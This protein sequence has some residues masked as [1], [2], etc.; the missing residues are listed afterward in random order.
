MYKTFKRITSN[1]I[2]IQKPL[3]VS[4]F[5]R[6]RMILMKEGDVIVDAAQLDVLLRT[7]YYYSYS[8]TDER[9]A[10]AGVEN[11]FDFIDHFK[12]NLDRLLDKISENQDRS[13]IAEQVRGMAQQIQKA[14]SVDSSAALAAFSLDSESPYKTLHHGHAAV[15]CEILARKSKVS[16]EDRLV[17]LSAMLTHDIGLLE[18]QNELDYLKEELDDDLRATIRTHPHESEA[19]LI[20]LGVQNPLWLRLVR[21]HHERI[22]GSGYPDGLQGDALD[23]LLR[24]I[25]LADTF[26][27][28]VRDRP[29]RKAM[30]PRYAL[31][32]ML[33]EQGEKIGADLTKL[34]IRE[35][36]LFPPGTIVTLNNGETGVVAKPR[37]KK[38]FPV[39][40]G[41]A[42]ANGMPRESLITRDTS[43]EC[44]AI[45]GMEHFSAYKKWRG[46]FK[47]IWAV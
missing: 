35:I 20:E 27:A 37:G 23:P 11:V 8:T 16:E 25:I 38:P 32:H 41:F 2:E 44:Y 28:M 5:S 39:V 29:Y 46:M 6:T 21:N 15:V 47:K 13:G 18:V 4:V 7:G 24:I 9:I 42:D 33:V 1:L 10:Q 31:R 12:L 22:D 19:M 43:E 17:M 36:G 3:P 40:M 34:L 14:V 30:L 45:V 26:S